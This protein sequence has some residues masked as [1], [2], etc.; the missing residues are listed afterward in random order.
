MFRSF[1]F[2]PLFFCGL[3]AP[4][5]FP[6]DR[7]S[8]RQRML[9]LTRANRLASP[10]RAGSCASH[11]KPRVFIGFASVY[12]RVG[13]HRARPAIMAGRA[14]Y[15]FCPRR[16]PLRSAANSTAPARPTA[17]RDCLRPGQVEAARSGLRQQSSQRLPSGVNGGRGASRERRGTYR[18]HGRS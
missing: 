7:R 10:C 2:K 9:L 1:P 13:H 15:P 16:L 5:I 11:N 4:G 8:S 18:R 3:R 14:S 12:L 6:R 17:A